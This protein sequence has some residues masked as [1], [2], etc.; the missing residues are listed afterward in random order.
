MSEDFDKE[1]AAKYIAGLVA[2]GKMTPTVAEQVAKAD[3]SEKPEAVYSAT[4]AVE[5]EV[6]TYEEMK[7]AAHSMSIIVTSNLFSGAS[8]QIQEINTS[9][10]PPLELELVCRRCGEAFRNDSTCE[11]DP[12]VI[13]DYIDQ[14]RRHVHKCKD[15]FWGVADLI[16]VSR[17]VPA[18]P[19]PDG[20]VPTQVPDFLPGGW[21]RINAKVLCQNVN[22]DYILRLVGFHENLVTVVFLAENGNRWSNAFNAQRNSDNYIQL[23]EY[24]EFFPQIME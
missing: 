11:G 6:A 9:T 7:K 8:G 23:K 19:A 24:R 15:S 2:F 14:G 22:E 12:E 1:K 20:A 17:R 13:Q 4:Q 3:L 16:G 18:K 5:D 10:E 21:V